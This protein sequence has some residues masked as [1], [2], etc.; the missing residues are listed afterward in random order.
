VVDEASMLDLAGRKLVESLRDDARLILL[1]DKD[2]LSSSSGAVFSGVCFREACPTVVWLEQ[3]YR[4]GADSAW[5]AGPCDQCRQRDQVV[6]RLRAG[7]A[8]IQWS[9]EFPPRADWPSSLWKAS[10]PS[11]TG[12][13]RQA[14]QE[15]FAVRPLPVLCSTA[16]VP[17]QRALAAAAGVV[18]PPAAGA[19][20]PGLVR[21]PAGAVT[22]NDYAL[23]CTTRRRHRA[24]GRRGKPAVHFQA[25]EAACARF[26]RPGWA[27]CRTAAI[28]CTGAGLE[29]GTSGRDRAGHGCGPDRSCCTRR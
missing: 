5:P 18:A 11:S 3:S 20:R 26:S 23:R 7:D 10:R 25:A 13:Y 12:A 28:P 1:G 4:F 24:A 17:R 21:G 6:A 14:A 22:A 16:K 8:A 19:R 29:F 2:Q 27:T 15:V 9:A